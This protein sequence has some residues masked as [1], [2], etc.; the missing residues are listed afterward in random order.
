MVLEIWAQGMRSLTSGVSTGGSLALAY[1]FL[2]WVDRQPLAPLPSELC[3]SLAPHRGLDFFSVVVGI[4]IGVVIYA[5]VDLVLTAKWA[6]LHWCEASR[7]ARACEA[8]ERK[9][10]YKIC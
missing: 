9:P 1:K 6:I 7:E 2:N 8:G 3:D 10:L 4:F 5:F